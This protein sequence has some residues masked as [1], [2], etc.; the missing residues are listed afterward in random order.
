M[1]LY[2]AENLSQNYKSQSQK[3]RVMSEQWMAENMFC[4]CCGHDVLVHLKNNRPV[5]DFYCPQCHNIFELKST[6][7]K[8]GKKIVDGTY[9]TMIERITSNTNPSLFVLAYQNNA[10]LNLKFIPKYFF[11]PEIVEKRKAL[12]PTAKRA[13]WIGCNILY[14]KIPSQGKISIIEN[15]LLHDKTQIIT[16]YKR[17]QILNFSNLAQRGWL[18]D[19]INCINM[20]KTD[21][22]SLPEIYRFSDLLAQKHIHNNNIQAKIRQQLQVLRDKGFIQFLGRGQYKKLY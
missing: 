15:S 17:S 18:F 13:G 7:K 8:I 2:F 12:P 1:N 19:I 22:F 14:D 5:A 3:I 16:A 6:A 20:I 9:N 4:P 21:R 10:V 11:V